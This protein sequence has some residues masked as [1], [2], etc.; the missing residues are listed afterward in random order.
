MMERFDKE[1][2]YDEQISPLMA[3]IIG[4]CQREGIPM[5]CTFAIRDDGDNGYLL[6]TSGLNGKNPKYPA[7]PESTEIQNAILTMTGRSKPITFVLIEK[8]GERQ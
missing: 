6:C 8:A 3:Q 1:N 5:A 2:V 4:I 7:M